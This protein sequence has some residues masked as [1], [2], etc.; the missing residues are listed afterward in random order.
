MD[1]H[2]P[3]VSAGIGDYIDPDDLVYWRE[4]IAGY[5]TLIW[6]AA[7]AEW[8]DI[9]A[10][11]GNCF[12]N[13]TWAGAK[14]AAEADWSA[15]GEASETFGPHALASGTCWGGNDYHS[16]LD[17][18]SARIGAN[19]SRKLA[20]QVQ[21]YA[22][23]KRMEGSMNPIFDGNGLYNGYENKIKKLGGAVSLAATEDGDPE[24]YSTARDSDETVKPNWCPIPTPAGDF[25]QGYYLDAPTLIVVPAFAWK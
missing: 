23:V 17:R 7:P 24:Y 3:S 16:H 13:A 11:E 1:F 15:G 4:I 8:C 12:Y 25:W 22:K 18:R 10:H 21:A 19:V 14:A 20:C 2:S 5:K 6:I 9:L